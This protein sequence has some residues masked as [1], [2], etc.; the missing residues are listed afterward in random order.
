M[1]S[2]T[3]YSFRTFLSP[4]VI[5]FCPFI[6]P[7]LAPGNHSHLSLR[8]PLITFCLYK[9][10]FS[11]Y[12]CINWIIKYVTFCIWLLLLSAFFWRSSMWEYVSILSFWIKMWDSV[13]CLHL[14]CLS[15]HSWWT[16]WYSSLEILWIVLLWT[17]VHVSLCWCTFSFTLGRYLGVQLLGHMVN[18]YLT[19]SETAKMFSQVSAPIYFPTI[20]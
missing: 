19:F 10:L 16:L 9:F 5:S 4:Q 14:F 17:S 18:L 2:L 13:V 15:I 6:T 1:W 8:K 11:R 12:F 7:T 3:K 20:N